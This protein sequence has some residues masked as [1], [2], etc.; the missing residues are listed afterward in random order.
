MRVTP[1]VATGS[2]VDAAEGA[3]LSGLR[4][5]AGRHFVFAYGNNARD[6][7][8]RAEY[9]G[10]VMDALEEAYEFVGEDLHANRTQPVTV[11]L[12]TKQEFDLHYGGMALSRAAGFFSGKIRINDAQ[13]L[14]PEVRSVIVHEYVHAVVEELNHGG[15]NCPVWIN[16]GLATKV[17][18]DWRSHQGMPGTD[19]GWRMQLRSMAA[20]NKLPT[21]GQLNQSFLNYPNPRLAYA[22]AGKGVELIIERW[23]TEAL[24]T[25]LRDAAEKPYAKLFAERMTPDLASLDADVAAALAK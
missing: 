2:T 23:G 13:E 4:E 10:R 22:T 15:N 12:Y 1:A 11:V 16:E 17:E 20:A 6:W 8:Q 3:A 14:T 19:D 5:R 21:L 18:N 24:V 25:L 9:E 7:G